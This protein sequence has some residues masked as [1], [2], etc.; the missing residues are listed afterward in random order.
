MA[1]ETVLTPAELSAAFRAW[2][3]SAGLTSAQAA[4]LAG[5]SRSLVVDLESRATVPGGISSCEALQAVTGLPVVATAA[6]HARDL[7]IA[8]AAVAAESADPEPREPA[9]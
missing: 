9:A 2:R 8:R 1:T 3:E 5:V 4:E 7:R 6:A